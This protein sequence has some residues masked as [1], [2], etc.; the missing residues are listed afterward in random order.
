MIFCQTKMQPLFED[1]MGG[2]L[3]PRT[4]EELQA[5][6]TEKSFNEHGEK[7]KKEK[8][9]FQSALENLRLD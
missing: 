8:V 2:G 9:S 6:T 4:R 1:T 7:Y 3:V 5:V